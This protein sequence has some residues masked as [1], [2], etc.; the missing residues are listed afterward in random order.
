MA[1]RYSI[2]RPNDAD[3]RTALLGLALAGRS[4]AAGSCLSDEEMAALVDGICSEKEREQYFQHLANCDVCYQDWLELSEIMGNDKKKRDKNSHHKVFRPQFFALAGSFLAAAASVVI[5]LQ[6]TGKA[7]SPVAPHQ[8]ME[9]MT[10]N[11]SFPS[12]DQLEEST[13]TK[14]MSRPVEADDD[15]RQDTTT[16]GVTPSGAVSPATPAM[17]MT[18]HDAA[19]YAEPQATATKNKQQTLSGSS[20]G[21]SRRLRTTTI[22]KSRSP[23]WLWLDNVKQGCLHNE[24]SLQFWTK[25]YRTGKQ[26]ATLQDPVEKQLIKVLLPLV[27]KLQRK[28]NDGQAVCEDILKRFEA[29]SLQ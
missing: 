29:I 19:G 20:G 24:T 7:P 9:T 18:D 3:R 11:K 27:G 1:K 8:S 25:Q 16:Y 28:G 22:R 26:L 17:K 4:G 6:I 21:N 12:R 13:V 23:G 10:R 15:K 2:P 5:F 14:S